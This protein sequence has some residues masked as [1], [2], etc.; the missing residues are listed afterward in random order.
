MT[1]QTEKPDSYIIKKIEISGP[2]DRTLLLSIFKIKV[3]VY[4]GVSLWN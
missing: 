1:D 3:L 2:K 4:F